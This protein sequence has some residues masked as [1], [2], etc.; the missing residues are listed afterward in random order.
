MTLSL[1]TSE[2]RIVTLCPT[3]LRC[4]A[5]VPGD[6]AGCERAQSLGFSRARLLILVI[7]FD[8]QLFALN[9]S[10]FEIAF[11]N[12]SRG[13]AGSLRHSRNTG[14]PEC[15]TPSTRSA[16]RSGSF[17]C[18]ISCWRLSAAVTSRSSS[19]M[20]RHALSTGRQRVDSRYKC[21]ISKT[22][23]SCICREAIFIW[24]CRN[25]P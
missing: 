21:N 3:L 11:L 8:C 24:S 23:D 25:E 7:T 15:M 18:C 22:G 19:S 16:A 9:S 10:S 5:A 13:K 1:K 17:I 4:W 20:S 14:A 12:Q 6:S 2:V